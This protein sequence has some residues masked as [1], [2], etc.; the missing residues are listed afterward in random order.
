MRLVIRRKDFE[1]LTEEEYAQFDSERANQKLIREELSDKPDEL[2]CYEYKL[3]KEVF[4][5]NRAE[6]YSN[7]GRSNTAEIYENNES[8]CEEAWEI[9]QGLISPDITIQQWFYRGLDFEHGSSVDASLG[10]LPRI[11]T[12]RNLDTQRI[13]GELMSK[14]EVQISTVE[15]AVGTSLVI[16]IEDRK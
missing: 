11:I 2:R 1:E 15:V 10:N 5:H 8:L 12:S 14:R 9:L 13:D 6:A 7:T 3:K 4:N 16:G